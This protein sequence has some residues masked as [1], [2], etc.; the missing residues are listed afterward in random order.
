M[1]LPLLVREDDDRLEIETFRQPTVGRLLSFPLPSRV[2]F[3][4][5]EEKLRSLR[6]RKPD[7]AAM[8][9]RMIDLY[10]SLP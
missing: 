7:K 1:S 2:A 10:Y 4:S 3:H 9:S 6:I 5:D 8:I